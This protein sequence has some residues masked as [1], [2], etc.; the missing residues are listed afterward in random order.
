MRTETDSYMEW[1]RQRAAVPE[2]RAR[3]DEAYARDH[4][5]DCAFRIWRE[6]QNGP[7]ADCSCGLWDLR[8]ELQLQYPTL[9]VR[10]E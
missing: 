9:I 8:R 5:S 6:A 7:L 3:L 1:M 10:G 2:L 4:E